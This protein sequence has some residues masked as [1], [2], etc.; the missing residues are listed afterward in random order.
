MKKQGFKLA[1]LIILFVIPL[2]L[3]AQDRGQ[4][5]GQ[6]DRAARMKQQQDELKKTLN[7]NKE[8]IVKFDKIHKDFDKKRQEMFTSMREGGDRTAMREKMGKMNTELQDAVKKILDKKQLKK[9]E[10]YLKKQAEERA[11]RA[12]RGGRGIR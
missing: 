3:M 1:A 11:N 6:G 8:Q 2:S 4:G 12:D 10:E 7:L 9:Y 5:R